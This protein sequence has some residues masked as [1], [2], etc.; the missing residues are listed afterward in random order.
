[1]D[2]LSLQV[3]REMRQVFESRDM[4]LYRMLS[5]HLGWEDRLGEPEP[6]VRGDRLYGAACLAT[7]VAAGFIGLQHQCRCGRC[8][9]GDG[10][11]LLSNPRRHRGRQPVP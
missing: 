2:D 5:Y 6:G 10:K 7:C 11:Q 1:M 4:S 8:C 3:D 9:R